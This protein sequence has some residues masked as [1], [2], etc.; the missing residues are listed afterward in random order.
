MNNK[1]G[2]LITGFKTRTHADEFVKWFEYRGQHET[3]SMLDGFGFMYVTNEKLTL[4]IKH[5]TILD[6]NHNEIDV[7][8]LKLEIYPGDS[9]E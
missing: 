9:D 3:E 5:E 2:V 7:S 4:P 8:Y 1:K 6:E